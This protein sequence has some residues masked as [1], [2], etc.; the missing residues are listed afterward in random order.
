[1]DERTIVEAA[2]FAATESLRVD[3]IVARTGLSEPDVRYALKDLK[4][5]YDMRNS[6]IVISEAAGNY[7]MV[8]RQEYQ[9]YIDDFARP[10]IPGG[11]MRTLV[12]IAYN[13]PVLQSKL[14]KVRGPRAYEDVKVLRSM[15]L[16]SASSNGQTKELSTTAKFAEQFGIGTNSKAAIRKWIEEN[17]SK[18]SSAGDAEE[19]DTAPEDKNDAS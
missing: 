2:L 8:L 10:A 17:S 5:E 18:S 3:D 19:E 16:V 9:K 15:G 4:M 7:R 13:Q 11:V 14:V 12:T 1:M 6:A